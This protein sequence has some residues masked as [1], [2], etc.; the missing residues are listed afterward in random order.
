L[1]QSFAA[2]VIMGY[3]TFVSLRVF[4]AFFPLTKA[5]NVFLQGFCAGV[6]GIII[7]IL[8]LAI[9]RNVEIREVWTTLHRKFWKSNVVVPDQESL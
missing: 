4:N 7:G 9:L 5:V 8:I 1:F 2:S 3:A 6:F